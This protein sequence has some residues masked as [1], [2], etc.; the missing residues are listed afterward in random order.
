MS[1]T[2]F[3]ILYDG[4]PVNEGTIDARDLA[5]ALLAFADL[6][7]QA[8]PIV[9]QRFPRL[10]VRVKS[11]FKEGSFEIF[12]EVTTLYDRFINIFSSPEIQTL[13][14]LLALLGINGATGLFQLI[15]KSKGRK[16]KNVTN[17]IIEGKKSIKIIFEEDESATVDEK[18]WKL[19]QNIDIRRT[20]EK[21]LSPINEKG[22]DLFKIKHKGLEKLTVTEKEA[23][24][25]IAPSEREMET[26][27]EIESRLII[28]SPSFNSWNK[29]RVSDGT[30]TIYVTIL[31][32]KFLQVI[33]KR[34][35]AFR[36]GDILHVILRITQWIESGKLCTEYNII[37][38]IK[39]EEGKKPD[40]LLQ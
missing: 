19:F 7:D 30:R 14:A 27:S 13:T 37:K 3:S 28:V 36:K 35:A 38:V 33:D 40:N 6:V 31:D 5:P 11:G 22:Y 34:E 16:P 24:Y 8:A 26:T 20:V 29:W 1:H 23:G 25:F 12:L 10:T 39:H 21:I 2:Q 9:D 15:L 17:I 4:L 32:E 18:V